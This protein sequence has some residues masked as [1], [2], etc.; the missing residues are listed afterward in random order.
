MKTFLKSIAVCAIFVLMSFTSHA[1]HKVVIQ[2][3]TAD[4]AAWSS[5]IGNIKNLQKIWPN[6]IQVEVVVHGKALDFL[7][8]KKTHLTSDIEG[9][10]STGVQF[11]ACENSMR[12]HNVLKEE[13]LKVAGTVPSGVAEVILKQESGWSYLKAG[14]N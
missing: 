7:V 5:T 11:N 14:V 13:L 8:S 6:N 3:N 9:L 4:T 1:Q 10:V 12:K 2:L